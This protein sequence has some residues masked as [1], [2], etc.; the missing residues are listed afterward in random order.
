MEEGDKTVVFFAKGS[1]FLSAVSRSQWGD[2]QLYFFPLTFRSIFL[3]QCLCSPIHYLLSFAVPLFPNLHRRDIGEPST[4]IQLTGI[5]A[6]RQA[7]S[8]SE[9]MEHF[10]TA[11]AFPFV[12]LRLLLLLL[13]L[14]NWQQLFHR[15][16]SSIVLSS[17]QSECERTLLLS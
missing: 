12:L 17:S 8:S 5:H 2:V 1:L 4:R 6:G 9:W 15:I 10:G 13:E 14:I 16:H 11:A 3:F 7:K